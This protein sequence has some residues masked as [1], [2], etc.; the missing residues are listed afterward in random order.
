MFSLMVNL[1]YAPIKC[2]PGFLNFILGL[3]LFVTTILLNIFI[4]MLVF[5]LNNRYSS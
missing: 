2:S 4:F 5:V 3:I 1:F